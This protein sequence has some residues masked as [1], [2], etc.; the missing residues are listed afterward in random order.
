MVF[1]PL[2]TEG[3]PSAVIAELNS[4]DFTTELLLGICE[5][6]FGVEDV[7]LKP[8]EYGVEKV[9]FITN[10]GGGIG[11]ILRLDG[12][13]RG[14]RKASQFHEALEKIHLITKSFIQK[15]LKGTREV[16]LFSIIQLDEPIEMPQDSRIHGKILEY[17]AEWVRSLE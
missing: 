2:I 8:A 7:L 4:P 1:T 11:V 6:I 16:Q 3:A 5:K 10:N 13:G 9:R 14:I 17:P 12:I 15:A